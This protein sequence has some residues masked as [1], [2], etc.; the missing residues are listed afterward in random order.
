MARLREQDRAR[1]ARGAVEALL[2]DERKRGEVTQELRG[3][4]ARIQACGLGQTLAFGLS[5][6]NHQRDVVDQLAKSLPDLPAANAK[7]LLDVIT[8]HM[9]AAQYRRATREALAVAEWMKR[10][11]VALGSPDGGQ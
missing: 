11:A 2:K 6:G 9:D 5:K 3:L 7:A 10:Y 1:R 4:P 8:D